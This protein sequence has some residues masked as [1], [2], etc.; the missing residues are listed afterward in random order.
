MLQEVVGGFT[1]PQHPVM[2]EMLCIITYWAIM[3]SLGKLVIQIC[4]KLVTPESLEE[5]S[6]IHVAPVH[7]LESGHIWKGGSSCLGEKI[8]NHAWLANFMSPCIHLSSLWKFS[9]LHWQL[10]IFWSKW[11]ESGNIE[12]HWQFVLVMKLT[13]SSDRSTKKNHLKSIWCSW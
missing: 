5:G 7:S 10:I 12:S 9:R 2:Y 3:W 4:G 1:S 8:R 11:D 13:L 6:C